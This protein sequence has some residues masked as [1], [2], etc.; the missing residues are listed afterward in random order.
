VILLHVNLQEDLVEI[1]V[2]ILAIVVVVVIVVTHDIKFLIL[3]NS[4]N[5]LSD[6]YNVNYYL[7]R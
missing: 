6:K 4:I 1:V 7:I 2:K 3:M 5:L